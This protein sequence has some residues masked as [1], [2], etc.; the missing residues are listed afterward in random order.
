MIDPLSFLAGVFVALTVVGVI[1]TFFD[2]RR[3]GT[4]IRSGTAILQ[5]ERV[6]DLLPDETAR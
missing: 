5:D 3:R 2:P 1:S 6:G 4:V